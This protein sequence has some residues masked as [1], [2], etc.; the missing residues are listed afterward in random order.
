MAVY[1][2]SIVLKDGHGKEFG[3]SQGCRDLQ[4][5]GSGVRS[6]NVLIEL[7]D[8]SVDPAAERS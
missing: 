2:L 6:Y 5:L 8:N 4:R 3:G 7:N 1:E